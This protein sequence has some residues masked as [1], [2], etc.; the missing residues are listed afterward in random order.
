MKLKNL[1]YLSLMFVFITGVFIYN[2]YTKVDYDQVRLKHSEF[3][4]NSPFKETKNLPKDQ[5]KKWSYHP[6]PMLKECG[7]SQ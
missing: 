3:L 1:K 6:M 5:R 4:K 2:N 7:S